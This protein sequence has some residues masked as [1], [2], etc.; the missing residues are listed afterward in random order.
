MRDRDLRVYAIRS[1]PDVEFSAYVESCSRARIQLRGLTKRAIRRAIRPS[2]EVVLRNPTLGEFFPVEVPDWLHTTYYTTVF[3]T[4]H[5]PFRSYLYRFGLSGTDLCS[6]VGQVPQTVRHILLECDHFKGLV[7]QSFPLRPQNLSY[8]VRDVT[9][10][11]K[12]MDLAKKIYD[13]LTQN[14]PLHT[15][16][17]IEH[18]P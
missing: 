1:V 8:F 12:F 9:S 15:D 5:G 14:R 10:Y 4:G 2:S 6:C 13:G 18:T 11:V 3:F 16:A 7:E 17:N